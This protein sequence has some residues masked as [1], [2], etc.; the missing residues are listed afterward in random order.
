MTK[1]TKWDITFIIST[2]YNVNM[3]DVLGP[4]RKHNLMPAR[5][6]AMFFC[7]AITDYSSAEIGAF[8]NR[9]HACVFYAR[10]K[11]LTAISTEGRS[12]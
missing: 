9:D 5:H 6:M 3:E 10:K 4:S 12:K 11:I 8:F 7:D 2:F 1:L